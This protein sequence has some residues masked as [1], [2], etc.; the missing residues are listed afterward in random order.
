MGRGV[1][2]NSAEALRWTRKAAERDFAPAQ[3]NLGV[4]YKTGLGVPQDDAEAAKWYHKAAEQGQAKAQ[5]NLGNVY[6]KGEGVARD[7]VLAYMWLNLAA[8][9]GIENAT[10]NREIAARRMTSTQIAEAQ[11]RVRQWRPN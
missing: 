4:L 11:N 2:K 10:Q 3:T 9:Q 7:D 6:L 8:N 1:G 5:F